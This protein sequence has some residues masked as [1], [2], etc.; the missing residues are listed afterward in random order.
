MNKQHMMNQRTSCLRPSKITNYDPQG[1]PFQVT[2]GCR[3]CRPCRDHQKRI[4]A[5]QLLAEMKTNRE[6][7][8]V[9]LTYRTEGEG[10][11]PHEFNYKTVQLYMKRLRKNYPDY[12][13]RFAI[14]G[15]RGEKKQRVHW[16]QTL[17][18]N[19]RKEGVPLFPW[20]TADH[21]DRRWLP[22]WPHGHINV[23]PLTRENATYS[24]KYAVKDLNNLSQNERPRQSAGRALGTDYI[25]DYAIRMVEA[26]IKPKNWRYKIDGITTQNGEKTWEWHMPP[27]LR[28]HFITTYRQAWRDRWGEEPR[29]ELIEDYF[30]DEIDPTEPMDFRPSFRHTAY[31]EP[32]VEFSNSPSKL[33]EWFDNEI[34]QGNYQGIPLAVEHDGEHSI[35]TSE[36]DTWRVARATGEQ[37]ERALTNITRTSRG[38]AFRDRQRSLDF[39]NN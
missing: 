2:V 26:G 29:V 15:E 22:E 27:S 34:R 9:T 19:P 32:W 28:K 12:E 17:F 8:M 13:F 33:Q 24:C 16:H 11:N 3:N 39:V 1:R 5:G 31:I 20:P 14:F 21:N 38:E 4:R 25:R 18:I 30:M 7:Y 37:V 36:T 35:L 6:A 10:M 23:K